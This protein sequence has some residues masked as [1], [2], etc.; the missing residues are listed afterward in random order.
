M[1]NNL[2]PL[3]YC[4]HFNSCRNCL[5]TRGDTSNQV[6]AFPHISQNTHRS[7]IILLEV[8]AVPLISTDNAN[9]S[10]TIRLLPPLQ[11]SR[12]S[13]Q[14]SLRRIQ[15]SAS[16]PSYLQIYKS[17]KHRHFRSDYSASAIHRQCQTIPHH[18]AIA[19]TLIFADITRELAQTPP[20]KHEPSIT[21]PK[22]HIN[23][24]VPFR[25]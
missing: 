20:I 17:I 10:L 24:T 18:Q 25:K 14:N 22:I 23:Q 3:G 12:K 7:N 11:F 1:P 4:L 9:Q 8:I 15:S 21:P 16:L 2:S 5:R 19:F 6:Q 13:L